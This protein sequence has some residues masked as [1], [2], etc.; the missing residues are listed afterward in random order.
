MEASLY[1]NTE[2]LVCQLDKSFPVVDFHLVIGQQN[3]YSESII[4]ARHTHGYAYERADLTVN[5]SYLHALHR[6]T[7]PKTS[8]YFSTERDQS[9]DSRQ[10]FIYFSVL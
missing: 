9:T 4:S 6:R 1:H 8:P 10:E 2:L 3:K 7:K 5:T